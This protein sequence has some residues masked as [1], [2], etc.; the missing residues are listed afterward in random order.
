MNNFDII[1]LVNVAV[2][3]DFNT[4]AFTTDE[5]QTIINAN[6]KKLFNRKLGLP[7]EYA[8]NAPIPREGV[9]ISKKNEQDLAPFFV[10]TTKAL[11][12]GLLD[13]T[14]E[15]PAYI[16]GVMP[17][18]VRKRGIDEV[19]F[20]ELQERLGNSLTE[21]TLDD[22]IMARNSRYQFTVY[23]TS[24]T[25][26]DVA[27]YKYPTD[28]VISITANSTTNLPEYNAGG[29]TELEW[30]DINKITIAYMTIRDAGMAIERN[31]VEQYAQQLISTGS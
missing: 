30:D 24:M 21:P 2:N 22:P 26:V 1:K 15:N 17:S 23:P 13:L 27:Y 18:T 28:C 3:R 29:S 25:S 11:A 10:R 16:I 12:T 4:F 20:D 19:T 7:E 5:Y 31:D 6:S 8:P 14:S 9:S